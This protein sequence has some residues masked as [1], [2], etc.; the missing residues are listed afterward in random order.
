MR[1]GSFSVATATSVVLT[2]VASTA[3]AGGFEYPENGSI[4]MGRGG[5][6]V[7]RASDAAILML[8][9]AGI[10]GL[11]G[12]QVT[13]SANVPMLSNCFTRGSVGGQP[14][15]PG[16]YAGQNSNPYVSVDGTD[17]PFEMPAGSGDAA[18]SD[19]D[20]PGHPGTPYP[21]VCNKSPVFVA[22]QLLATY[23]VNRYF[24]IGL[25]VYGPNSIGNQSFDTTSMSG[26]FQVPSPNR[27]MLISENLLVIYPTLALAV[28]P[29]RWLRIGAAIQPAIAQF[30][31]ATMAN[32]LS[33]QSPNSDIETSA[34]TSGWFFAANFGVQLVLPH[35]FTLAGALHYNP[36]NI[37]L[38]GVATV[39]GN[40]Y[41]T[42][43]AVPGETHMAPTNSNFNINGV[44]API[45]MQVHLPI[46]VKWGVR[47]AI[48]SAHAL[49]AQDSPR[50]DPMRDDAFDIEIDWMYETA[51]VFNNLTIK[52]QP[53]S[54]VNIGGSNVPAPA[55][56]QIPHNYHDVWGIRLGSDINIVPNTF[57][58][59]LGVS[60]EM[61]AQSVEYAQLDLPS[62]NSL[63]LHA[64][65]SLRFSHFTLSLA[66]AHFFMESIDV[67]A[68]SNGNVSTIGTSGAIPQTQCSVAGIGLDACAVNV[69]HYQASLD[70]L[71]AGISMHF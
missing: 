58:F 68:N 29:V 52:S 13:L 59:R 20:M 62:Y 32:Y 45:D 67:L 64:G 23:R 12:L 11:D 60:Y 27:Y 66:Y 70:V 34:T 19:A 28:A 39:T 36:P 46:D 47:L 3:S 4:A 71:N 65:L 55:T 35:Y 61:G 40:F 54:E 38:N 18:Y 5:A 37:D 69:G 30:S 33:S 44:D 16:V 25:G 10:V 1:R 17:T 22:P 48:P 63:G 57:A 49:A 15:H 53:L 31:F 14:G 2:C 9:P 41:H 50:Y 8:N 6:S 24:A 26:G 43:P 51:S 56:I 42:G 7:A 21:T